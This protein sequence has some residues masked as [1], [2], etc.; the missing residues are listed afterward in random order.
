M[1]LT[2]SDLDLFLAT[3]YMGFNRISIWGIWFYQKPKKHNSL[4][5]LSLLIIS[6]QGHKLLTTWKL[7]LFAQSPVFF[8]NWV[9]HQVYPKFSVGLYSSYGWLRY[10]NFAEL[11]P[12][13]RQLSYHQCRKLNLYWWL[14]NPSPAFTDYG[15][16]LMNS[17]IPVAKLNV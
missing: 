3:S 10:L 5:A 4:W 9:G 16:V 8:R 6:V 7:S 17:N 14:S 11:L 1:P 13:R 2:H 15:N 12:V